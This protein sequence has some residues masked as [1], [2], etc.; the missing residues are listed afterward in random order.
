M[1][2]SNMKYGIYF[3]VENKGFIDSEEILIYKHL[4][5][6]KDTRTLIDKVR[7]EME[8]TGP[9]QSLIQGD[10]GQD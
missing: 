6:C 9:T 8:V 7:E 3:T 5:Y 10:T 4:F 1:I 2:C